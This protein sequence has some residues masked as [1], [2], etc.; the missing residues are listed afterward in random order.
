VINKQ[1]DLVEVLV[2]RMD[3]DRRELRAQEDSKGKKPGEYDQSSQFTELL[4]TVWDH[5]KEGNV[6]KLKMSIDSGRFKPN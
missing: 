1:R 4:S 6:R 5:A 2:A 3:A